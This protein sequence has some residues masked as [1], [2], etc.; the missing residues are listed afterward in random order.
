M[1][2]RTRRFFF[3]IVVLAIGF[4][5][6]QGPAKGRGEIKAGNRLLGLAISENQGQTWEQAFAEAM[7]AGVNYVELPIAWDDVETT[8]GI[9]E[10]NPDWAR[11]GGEFYAKNGVKVALSFLSIDTTEDRRPKWWQSRKWNDPELVEAAVAVVIRTLNAIPEIARLS[12]SLGNEVDIHLGARRAQQRAYVKFVQQLRMRLREKGVGVPIGVK[13]TAAG[14][15]GAEHQ[16]VQDISAIMDVAMITYYPIDDR[17]HAR[18]PD[19]VEDDL[20]TILAHLGD[21]P[22]HLSEIGYPS[23]QDCGSS[24]ADQARF[25]ANAFAAWDRNATRIPALFWDWQSDIPADALAGYGD[26]YGLKDMCFLN[27]LATLGLKTRAGTPKAGWVEFV[28]QAK[29]RDFQR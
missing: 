9:F 6:W 8:P 29:A 13:V 17:F 22:V 11:I 4:L 12:I 10:P 28:N 18:G 19:T 27:Y 16:F 15:L 23:G 3:L 21:Q 5:L 7:A 2:R 1:F 20:N 24:P 14:L 26:Y 25:V